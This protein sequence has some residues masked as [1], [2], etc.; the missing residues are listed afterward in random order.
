MMNVEQDRVVIF[1]T[2][3]RDGEQSPG[4]S[5]NVEEKIEIADQLGRLGVDIIEAGFPI[6]SPGDFEAVQG[7]AEVFSDR[8]TVICGLA[9]NALQDI[10]RCW[11]AIEPAQNRRIHTF[12]ATSEIHM[13]DKLKMTPEQV[14]E[15][16][17]RS[18]KH[19]RQYTDDV[20]FSPEDASR[21]DF[22]FMCQVLQVAVDNGATTLNIPDTVGHAQPEEYAKRIAAIRERVTGDY[23]LSTHCHNDLGLA[24]ANTMAG[25]QAG[26][27][28]VEV[29]VNGIG[30]R[31]GNAALEEVVMNLT[32]RSDYFG[33]VTTGVNTQLIMPTSEMVSRITRYPVQFNKAIVGRNAFAHEAGI[34]QHGVIQNRKTYE[35]MDPMSVGQTSTLEI[36]KHSGSHA[37]AMKLEQLGFPVTD[38]KS[39]RDAC[40]QMC[41]EQQGRTLTDVEVEAIAMEVYGMPADDVIR[42]TGIDTHSRD[43]TAT[44]HI[45][46]DM[47]GVSLETNGQN[48]GE[49]AAAE[50]AIA[51]LFPDYEMADWKAGETGTEHGA[52]ATGGIS[53]SVVSKD[54]Q[55]ITTYAEHKNVVHASIYAMVKGINCAERTKARINPKPPIDNIEG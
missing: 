34:H 40:K 5:M 32:Y 10:D 39:V 31:A 28:Q 18:V 3:L 16:A 13:R 41:E 6:S 42:V 53:C 45:N 46:C 50:K 33:G 55:K 47:G 15:E 35:I 27:R 51:T 12:I 11:E 38:T 29:A 4:I 36:G 25:V 44:V 8:P 2:T 7:V 49:I 17:A 43:D 23:V 9:R 30:E 1:D 48:G 24:V 20:E 21:S 37:I 22:D 26:A 52:K 14:I 54:G 19:A